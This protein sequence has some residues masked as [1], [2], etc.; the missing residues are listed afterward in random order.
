MACEIWK[1]K[2]CKKT[3]EKHYGDWATRFRQF[4][5]MLSALL[6]IGE[7]YK[8]VKNPNWNAVKRAFRN[9]V[10]VMKKCPYCGNNAILQGVQKNGKQDT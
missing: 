7:V 5:Q 1:C 3:F 2:T 9:K 8:Q 6:M 4:K 10:T